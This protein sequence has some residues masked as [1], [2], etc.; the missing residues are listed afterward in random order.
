MRV[1][2]DI[3]AEDYLDHSILYQFIKFDKS[4]V[5][6]QIVKVKTKGGRKTIEEL[7]QY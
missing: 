6:L 4:L 7:K 1:A 2:T 5:I 3:G